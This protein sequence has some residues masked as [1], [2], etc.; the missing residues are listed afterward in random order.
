MCNEINMKIKR[1]FKNKFIDEIVYVIEIDKSM[2]IFY[3]G[4]ILFS[5]ILLESNSE[6]RSIPPESRSLYVNEYI[7][8]NLQQ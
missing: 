7:R 8:Y 2:M 1:I 5:I 3:L 6:S 4:G